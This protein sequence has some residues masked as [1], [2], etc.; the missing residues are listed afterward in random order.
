MVKKIKT[1]NFINLFIIETIKFIY[2]NKKTY[3]EFLTII[4]TFKKIIKLFLE[5]HRFIK[6]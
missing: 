5:N 3:I 4:I 6:Y 1:G 2:Y